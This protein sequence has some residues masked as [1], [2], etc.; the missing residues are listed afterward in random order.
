[1]SHIELV[2]QTPAYF[3]A[4]GWPPDVTGPVAAWIVERLQ[5][6]RTNHPNAGPFATHQVYDFI[7]LR[8]EQAP[9]EWRRATLLSWRYDVIERALRYCGY[10]KRWV[11]EGRIAD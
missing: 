2:H 4:T 11:H 3:L 9:E 7:R 5:Q 10:E 1:M 8:E 6:L